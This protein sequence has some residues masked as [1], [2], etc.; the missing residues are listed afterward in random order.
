MSGKSSLFRFGLPVLVVLAGLAI[1]FALIKGRPAPQKTEKERPGALVRTM[2]VRAG[3][4]AAVVRG[5][6][7]VAPERVVS[8]APQVSGIVVWK[9]GSLTPGGFFKKGEKLFQIEKADYELAIRQAEANLTQAQYELESIKS[10]A[11]IARAEWEL[12]SEDLGTE[13]PNPLV[14]YEPQLKNAEAALGSAAAS[15][16]LA[17]LN[18]KRTAVYAPFD[19][20][21]SSEDVEVGKH[22][23][24]G[25][26]VVELSGTEKAEI[27]VSLHSDD[28]RWIDIPRA[29]DGS[30]GSK[31]TVSMSGAESGRSWEGF[32][33][34]S[35]GEIDTMSRMARVVV[36]VDDPYG[37]SG[38]GSRSVLLDGSFV[39][40]SIEGKTMEDVV[41]LPRGAL[42]DGSTVWLMDEEGRLRIRGVNVVRVEE[43]EVFVSNG[44]ADG[45]RVVLTTVSGAADGMKLRD[46]EGEAR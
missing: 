37:A 26:P 34:R 20:R 28:L 7:N 9:A 18:L 17:G 14:L 8:I 19:C 12:L 35:Y 40:V 4:R 13:E 5:T 45:D 43:D 10:R 33:V 29:G 2:V 38:S 36:N 42:R 32:V 15:V 21:V 25:S 46:A 30:R 16:E 22:V 24:A 6:A 41:A 39:E 11:R 27:V 23:Q 44:I 3:D 1:M 31:A